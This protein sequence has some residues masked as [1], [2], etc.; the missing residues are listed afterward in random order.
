MS[1]YI[2]SPLLHGLINKECLHIFVNTEIMYD[3]WEST[4]KNGWYD[5]MLD[6]SIR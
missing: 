1:L 5:S 4:I 2:L 6:N 3:N